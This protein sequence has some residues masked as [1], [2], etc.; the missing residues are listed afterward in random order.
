ME[1]GEYSFDSK[2]TEAL[3]PFESLT[4][5]RTDETETFSLFNAFLRKMD[6]IF[7]IKYIFKKFGDLIVNSYRTNMFSQLEAKVTPIIYI[8]YACS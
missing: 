5:F 6:K 8:Y 4:S 1:S 7:N 2:L 3:N